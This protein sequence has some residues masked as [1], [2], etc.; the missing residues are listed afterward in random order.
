MDGGRAGSRAVRIL[1]SAMLAGAG[2]VVWLALSAG[3][4]TADTGTGTDH[5]PTTPA[6]PA[7]S[8]LRSAGES[9]LGS[10]GGVA[11]TDSAA[12]AP[13]SGESG[14][15]PVTAPSPATQLPVAH[16][17][18]AV[19]RLV[20]DA[21]LVGAAVPEGTVS[22]V[23]SPGTGPVG[24]ALDGS[25]GALVPSVE[26]VLQPIVGDALQPVVDAVV[27]PV[28]DVVEPVVDAIVPAVP[29]PVGSLLDSLLGAVPGSPASLVVENLTADW[30][31]VAAARTDPLLTSTGATPVDDRSPLLLPGSILPASPPSNPD[32]PAPWS[33]F[34][35]AA[36]L[37]SGAAQVSTDFTGAS[38]AWL[39]DGSIFAPVAWVQDGPLAKT[40][41]P[42]PVSFDPGSSPD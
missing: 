18:E 32:D 16:A 34:A 35:W 14:L 27:P 3:T 22:T 24:E 11:S 41:L 23:T 38:T 4:A 12:S 36:D 25:P 13:V 42:L 8:V 7:A 40:R 37:V 39:Q 6:S 28:V 2:A 29:A 1:R 21:P 33:P 31:T 19:D 17:T 9:T 26:P 20:A 30:P 10:L 15:A 5:S